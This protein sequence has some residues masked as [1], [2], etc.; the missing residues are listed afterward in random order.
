MDVMSRVL[1]HCRQ[2]EGWLGELVAWQM[3]FGHAKLVRWGLAHVAPKKADTILDIGCG[4]GGA[5]HTLATIANEGQVH[6]VDYSQASIRVSRR[7]NRRLIVA[8]RVD[9]RHGQVSN[10]PYPD[11]MFDF[12]TAFETHY[13]WPDLRGDL[14]EVLRI[15]KPGGVLVIVGE[16]YLGG[17]FDERNVQWAELTKMTCYSAAELEEAL[18]A[19]RYAQFEVSVD[20]NQGWIC[21][22]GR[23]PT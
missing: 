8:G 3:N 21:A 11:G 15:L 18:H 6:G 7:K 17:K 5:V 19:A 1:E 23:R 20:H 16:A 12:V 22:V 14:T 9:I 13:Y 2:P 4:G 10:L